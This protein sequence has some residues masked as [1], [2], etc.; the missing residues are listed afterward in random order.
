[1][2]L[3]ETAQDF[4]AGVC[5]RTATFTALNRPGQVEA[6][7]GGQLLRGQGWAVALE[8]LPMEREEVAELEAFL[9]SL[10]GGRGA[11]RLGDP[12][13]SYP[14]G[15]ATG[16]PVTSG[17]VKGAEELTVTGWTASTTGQLLANDKIEIAGHLYAVLS[18]ADSDGAGAST[19]AVW[20]PLRESYE[21]ATTVVTSNARGTFALEGDVIFSRDVAQDVGLNLAAREVRS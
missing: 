12:F 4:P 20:P 17:A 8:I 10:R 6:T 13:Q 14:L 16:T 11:F 9:L 3:Y 7:S 18:D 2:A 15:A 19:V 21:D 5:V 1:M